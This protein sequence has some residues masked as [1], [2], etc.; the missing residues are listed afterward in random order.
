LRFRILWFSSDQHGLRLSLPSR[1]P[2]S[3]R[4]GSSTR[5]YA[6]R[7]GHAEKA[8]T[9]GRRAVGKV[10]YLRRR[11][12]TPAAPI[13]TAST[14]V[15]SGSNMNATENPIVPNLHWYG[16]MVQASSWYQALA[17]NSPITPKPRSAA[18]RVTPSFA[19]RIIL[20]IDRTHEFMSSQRARRGGRTRGSYSGLM[21]Q[22]LQHV[23]QPA[24]GEHRRDSDDGYLLFS[25]SSGLR[26]PCVF[27]FN[28]PLGSRLPPPAPGSPGPFL[29]LATARRRGITRP[30]APAHGGRCLAGLR[31]LD[32]P[33]VGCTVVP[34]GRSQPGSGPTG[35]AAPPTSSPPL[36]PHRLIELDRQR[37]R[38]SSA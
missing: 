10:I 5:D 24:K 20:R 15:P 37:K 28:G 27:P 11:C 6:A 25:S 18:P 34:T 14:S 26:G 21:H 35:R 1:G 38:G 16:S 13:E 19:T 31:Y 29:V 8:Y 3:F 32:N 4:D 7:A 23:D 30:E 33:P 17:T 36:S 9:G 22:S 12:A 2:S